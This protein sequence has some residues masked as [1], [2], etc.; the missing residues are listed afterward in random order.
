[1]QSALVCSHG[2]FG[3]LLL[4][5]LFTGINKRIISTNEFAQRDLLEIGLKMIFQNIL[6]FN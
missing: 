4:G 3:I 2:G 6:L 5:I 1:M